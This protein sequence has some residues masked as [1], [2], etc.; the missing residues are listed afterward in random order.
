[1]AEESGLAP[2]IFRWFWQQAMER[3][4]SMNAEQR[5]GVKLILPVSPSLLMQ[6]GGVEWI[7]EV[8]QRNGIQAEQIFV[9]L[10]ESSF[11]VRHTQLASVLNQLRK[12]GFHLILDNFG[13]GFAPLKLLRDIPYS[14]LRLGNL[15]VASIN[16]SRGDRAI[17]KG[18]LNLAHEMGLMVM[19]SEVNQL[20]QYQFLRESG[21]DWLSGEAV[22]QQIDSLPQQMEAMGMFVFPG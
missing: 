11:A 4:A 16:D 9:E 2:V 13:T 6:E 20:E 5:E 1:M 10:P 18:V 7:T 3:V 8:V 12:N 15:F 17:I 19:A 21:C 14:L 22:L